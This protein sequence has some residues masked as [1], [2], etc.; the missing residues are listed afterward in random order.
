MNKLVVNQLDKL[1]LTSDAGTI[2]RELEIQHPAAR[3]ILLASQQQD[4]DV[5]DG[6][7]LVVVLAGEMLANAEQLLRIGMSP[8]IIVE[9][10]EAA[11]RQAIELMEGET[12]PSMAVEED[13]KGLKTVIR[14]AI[15]SKQSGF[16]DHLADLIHKAAQIAM[17]ENRKG[18]NLDNV[19]CVK[20]I[21]GSF[22]TGSHVVRGMVLHR[23]PETQLKRATKAKVA[24]FACP[25][26]V[27]QTET[28][29][30]VLLKD[31]KEML[32]FSKGEE[33]IIEA[34]IK[35]IAESGVKVVVTG[36]QIGELALHFLNRYGLLAMRIQSK[37][38]LRRFC[39]A[40]GANPLAR[41][42]A[43]TEEEAGFADVVECVE[44][45]GERCTV[46]R[47]EAEKNGVDSKLA[48]IVLRGNTQNQLDDMERAIEDGVNTVKT[49]LAKDGR[50]VAGAGAVELEL[51]RKLVAFG[52]TTPGMLQYGI[53]AYGQAFEAIPRILA[54]NAGFNITDALSK[55]TW[56]HESQSKPHAAVDLDN[57]NGDYML[58]AQASGIVDLLAVKKSAIHL[59]TEAALT[60]LRVDQIIMSKPAGGPKPRGPAP[61][62]QDD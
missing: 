6:T 24:V 1:F 32:E 51:A 20:I 2:L 15:A 29:S 3:L 47:Q 49:A 5:G 35:A 62:D 61:Q 40:V 43:P 14:S 18:F 17:P 4:K 26:N 27:G 44:I 37:F 56:A 28:K 60:V 39:R 36:D 22:Q 7:N 41:L 46:I 8:S 11:Y 33:Q 9:G 16:E 48:T 59:A 54:Q 25:I 52:E 31:A 50:V 23:E 30:T 42:G 34:Q 13:L 12:I 57:C 55:L 38:E 21:G 58:D 19:R 45:G 53:K 10:F